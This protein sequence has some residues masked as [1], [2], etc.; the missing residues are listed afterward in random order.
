MLVLALLGFASPSLK[1]LR[2]DFQ[3]Q[4]RQEE[5]VKSLW[6][7][8]GEAVVNSDKMATTVRRV[9]ESLAGSRRASS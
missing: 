2:G 1:L 6:E 9:D 7:R 4:A 5:Y 8:Y 3:V